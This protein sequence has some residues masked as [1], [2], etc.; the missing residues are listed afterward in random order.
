MHNP[1]RTHKTYEVQPPKPMA[2]TSGVWLTWDSWCTDTARHLSYT[3][4]QRC[5]HTLRTNSV[6]P[7]GRV[8]LEINFTF[9]NMTCRGDG[10][11]WEQADTQSGYTKSKD[12]EFC[13]HECKLYR[14]KGCWRTHYRPMPEWYFNQY[15]GLC[16]EC[17]YVISH[18]K[19][20]A[21]RATK[22]RLRKQV[23]KY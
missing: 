4:D 13:K 3:V 21:E 6:G 16:Q 15:K 22:E 12:A 2:Q 18:K 7:V 10:T 11:C 14:C 8:I 1:Y 20:K 17:R 9:Q 5:L 19:A 23:L